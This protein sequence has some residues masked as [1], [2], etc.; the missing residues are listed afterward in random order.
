MNVG[1]GGQSA[2]TLSRSSGTR[3]AEADM[4]GERVAVIGDIHGTRKFVDGYENILKN[5][6]D[7]SKIIVLGDHFDP[8]KNIKI[9]DMVSRFNDF[10]SCMENDRRIVSIL[11]NHDLSSYIIRGDRTNRT[12]FDPE[13]RSKIIDC[14]TG[15]IDK[16]NLIFEYGQYLFS[17][18][19]V[20]QRWME[21]NPSYYGYGMDN[22][23][24][25]GWSIDELP[26][27]AG[28]DEGDFSGWGNS[29]YQS[30]TWIRPAMLCK[31]P[32]GDY[33]QVVGHTMVIEEGV[34]EYIFGKENDLEQHG[35]FYK[36]KMANGRDLW[37]TD[38][39]GHTD[40][41]VLEI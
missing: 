41:L 16:S 25:T 4:S 9:V 17:H 19:G 31:Y 40:Y 8:Y 3:M 18:A 10:V 27:F 1:S 15:I 22:L 34:R 35:D 23:T 2:G 7:V 13:K 24:K 30:P 14:I 20:S 26:K 33:N 32:Y 5:D 39:A 29:P 11:G 12:E 38:N 36:A 6:N 28:Y 21:G 37:F